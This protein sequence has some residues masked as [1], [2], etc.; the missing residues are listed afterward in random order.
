MHRTPL[1]A[2]AIALVFAASGCGDSSSSRPTPTPTTQP[3]VT[4]TPTAVWTPTSGPT[5]TPSPTSC[6]GVAP[7]VDPI[8]SPTTR[9]RVTVRGTGVTCGNNKRVI[10]QG[11]HDDVIVE[12]CVNRDQFDVEVRLD[13]GRNLIRVCQFSL[14]PSVCTEIEVERRRG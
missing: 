14:C 9:S 11:P 4:F 1:A 6:V 3:T 2:F 5:P 8:D 12:D 13:L 10:I 7:A